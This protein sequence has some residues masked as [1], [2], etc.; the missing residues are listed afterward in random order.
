MVSDGLPG[1]LLPDSSQVCACAMMLSTE[2]K[3]QWLLG[4]ALRRES[5]RVSCR[6]M[7][8]WPLHLKTGRLLLE[9]KT[10]LHP[11]HQLRF[12]VVLCSYLKYLDER[13]EISLSQLLVASTC[14]PRKGRLQVAQLPWRHCCCSIWALAQ[15]SQGRAMSVGGLRRWFRFRRIWQSRS[16]L[17]DALRGKDCVNHHGHCGP[18]EG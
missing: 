5:K 12:A 13:R 18:V 1:S 16:C 6:E 9:W 4:A 17:L 10:L 14:G 3:L 7:A 8:L 2:N 11:R 15:E